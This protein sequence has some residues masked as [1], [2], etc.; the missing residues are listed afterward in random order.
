MNWGLERYRARPN[1]LERMRF[2]KWPGNLRDPSQDLGNELGIGKVPG[3]SESVGEDA[4]SKDRVDLGNELGIGKV[5][6]SS[7]SVG[8]DAVSKDRVGR[9]RARLRARGWP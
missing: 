3:S 8:E 7:E 1:P 4:V 2:R 9:A 6:G 5:P